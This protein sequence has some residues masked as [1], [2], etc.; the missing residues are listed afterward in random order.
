MNDLAER[1]NQIKR[2]GG[3]Y[4]S[5]IAVVIWL[6][7]SSSS[8]A[9]AL[10]KLNHLGL[11]VEHTHDRWHPSPNATEPCFG[12]PQV[13][14][15]FNDESWDAIGGLL[16]RAWF[17]RL[18][19]TQ[20]ARL[21]RSGKVYCGSD[22][23]PWGV[24]RRAILTLREK[25][26]LPET[27]FSIVE[28]ARKVCNSRYLNDFFWL[29]VMSRKRKCADPRDKVY[30][31]LSLCPSRLAQR[32]SPQLQKSVSD[33]YKDGFLAYATISCR[34]DLLSHINHGTSSWESPSWV[35]DWSQ[36]ADILQAICYSAAAGMSK[37]SYKVTPHNTLRVRGALV[38]EVVRVD[39]VIQGEGDRLFEIWR[40]TD[41]LDVQYC[42]GSRSEKHIEAFLDL[43]LLGCTRERY[44]TNLSYLSWKDL[45]KKYFEEKAYDT[46]HPLGMLPGIHT[47]R[48]GNLLF[49]TLSQGLLGL[50]PTG[51]APGD[52][53]CVFLG[54]HIPMLLRPLPSGSG[55]KAIGP[56]QTHGIMDGEA[57]LGDLPRP[58]KVEFYRDNIGVSVL[59]FRNEETDNLTR[60]DPRL[61]PLPD[62]WE[63]IERDRTPHDSRIFSEFRHK[64]TGEVMNSDPRM[65]GDELEK[66]GVDLQTFEIY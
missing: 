14:L 53:V 48:L 27:L 5:A 51:T 50:A 6:G 25:R 45:E 12:D 33:V 20:E 32:I 44:P 56:T 55:Y 61:G 2:M 39:K 60:N 4:N 1:A 54:C 49:I 26:S 46:P 23:I 66:R 37:P 24:F 34:L 13:P 31:I 57:I 28:Q 29:T 3:I 64:V 10:E 65:M 8:S 42:S 9:L 47:S 40:H 15:P 59:H 16:S 63:R 11:Q 36:D 52:L 43:V 30:G 17:E 7:E 21:A 18:W 38:G 41:T 35:P 62:Q 22:H 58:W 19:V